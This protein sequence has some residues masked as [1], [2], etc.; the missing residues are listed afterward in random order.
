M[1]PHSRIRM[2]TRGAAFLLVACAPVTLTAQH[3]VRASQVVSFAVVPVHT[4]SAAPDAA[5]RR[6]EIVTV[7]TV[8]SAGAVVD[9]TRPSPP[10]TPPAAGRPV[11]RPKP[12][13]GVIITIT[14]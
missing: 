14:E 2:L 12:P 5:S 9:P 13:A 11:R 6:G 4:P 1:S 10:R 3:A 7:G 8:S